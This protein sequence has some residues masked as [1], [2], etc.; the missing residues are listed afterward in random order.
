MFDAKKLLDSIVAG[1][2]Q[3][4]AAD[5]PGSGGTIVGDF[6]GRLQ[7]GA[8]GAGLQGAPRD[9]AKQVARQATGGVRDVAGKVDQATGAGK[10]IEDIVRQVSG[11]KS[12]GDLIA[13]AKDM[14]AKNPGA[15]GALAGVLGGI[16]LGTH[17]GR[18]LT[19]GAAKLGGLV[20]IGGLAYK[21]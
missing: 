21:A 9:M 7:K 12:A 10:A 3:Q 17:G 20:L 18:G 16:L 13:Q 14:I 5:E 6:W 1:S 15:A 2:A 4:A 19:V 11:G 8:E